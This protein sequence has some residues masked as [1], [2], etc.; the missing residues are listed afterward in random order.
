MVSTAGLLRSLVAVGVVLLSFPGAFGEEPAPLWAGLKPGPH[1]VG[2]RSLWQFDYSRQ[3]HMTFADKSAHAAEKAPR[4]IL[5]NIWYPAAKDG[6]AKRMPHGDYFKIRSDDPK[7]GK[8]SAGLAEYNRDRL[9]QELLRK[10]VAKL[11]SREKQLL[12]EFFKTPT[13]CVRAAAAAGGTFPLVIYHAGA[14][15]SFEDNSVLCEFLASHGFVV[16]GSAFQRGGDS[17]NTDGRDRSARDVEFLIAYSRQLPGVDWSHV[18]LVGHS[19]GAQA[20][21][22]YASQTDC[23]VDA[24]VSLD[25]TQDYHGLKDPTWEA[26]FTTPVVKRGKNFVC[27]LVMAAESFATFELADTFQSSRRYYLT[28]KEM[29]HN[30]FISQGLVARD[31]RARIHAGDA[32]DTPAE[33][34]DETPMTRKDA[35]ARARAGYRSLCVFVLQFLTAELKGDAAG[36]EFLAKHYRDTTLGGNE[37]HVEFTPPG[38]T[39]PDPYPASSINPPTP[40][41]LRQLYRVEGVSKTIAVLKRFRKQAPSAPVYHQNFELYLVCD[42]LDEGKAADAVAFRDY[43]RDCGHDYGELI[44]KIAHSAQKSGITHWAT[45][46]YTRALCLDPANREA[47]EQL[48]EL[49]KTE[50][51][52]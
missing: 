27:P 17:F 46:F 3:F 24:V 6:M 18:G 42:L 33:M 41:Q 47:A 16:L 50:K 49:A 13:A 36:K 20:A 30:D 8:F 11:A 25:T 12:E 5:I 9:T 43:Y 10:P 39:G 7:L 19:L 32:K 38:R 35:L 29:G 51:K 31:L 23:A 2:F 28:F 1:T 52:P 14:G 26:D 4:P 48:K 37:P 15:S 34:E 22:Y 40:R 21:L 45:I 44:L